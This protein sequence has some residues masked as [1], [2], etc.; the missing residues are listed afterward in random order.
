MQGNGTEGTYDL[1]EVH[2]D[3]LRRAIP[4]LRS[5]LSGFN[6]TI[7]LKERI[8]PLLDELD[9]ALTAVGASI[10]HL[11]IF[12]QAA[13][14]YIK[15]SVCRNGEEPGVEGALDAAPARIHS[16][17]VNLRASASP[18]LLLEVVDR[19]TGQ[20]PGRLR[21]THREAFR[22]AAPVPEHRLGQ[23]WPG[24]GPTAVVEDE[25]PA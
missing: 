10:A 4:A 5:T 11:K 9:R 21:I 18:A 8:L 20:I 3:E 13:T 14:G 1:I 19:A 2:P 12:T 17:V 15:A 16:V 22:P 6:V 25:T 24:T 23:G 7:P